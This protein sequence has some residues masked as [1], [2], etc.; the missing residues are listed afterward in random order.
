[1]LLQSRKLSCYLIVVVSVVYFSSKQGF[2]GEVAQP[3]MVLELEEAR[4]AGGDISGFSCCPGSL[5]S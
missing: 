5:Q 2:P 3:G 1:M 4:A